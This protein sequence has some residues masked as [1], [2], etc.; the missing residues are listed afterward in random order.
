M[1]VIGICGASGSGKSRLAKDLQKRLGAR[2]VYLIQDSY[3]KDHPDMSFQERERINYDEP[4][5]FEHEDLYRDLL[6]LKAGV[7]ITRRDYDYT[8]H[9]RA[10]RDEL[11][12][13]ADVV[14]LE[15]IHVFYDAKVRDM[16]DVKIFMHTD[17][18]VCIMRRAMRDVS[19]RAR[20]IESVFTQYIETVKPMYERH[21]RLYSDYAD[22]IVPGTG[23]NDKVIDILMKYIDATLTEK[24]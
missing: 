17:P 14:I 5:A 11:I 18:D 24:K 22:L 10:D 9:R 19:N 13:P 4:E 16:L 7:A 8:I 23:G 2:C 15:G 3:Y 6:S 21:I 1:L 20:S 12:Y